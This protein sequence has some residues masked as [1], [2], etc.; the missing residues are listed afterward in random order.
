MSDN[1]GNLV[2]HWSPSAPFVRK[3]S[4]LAMELGLDERIERRRTPVAP[5]RP[6]PTLLAGDNPLSKLPAMILPDGN[7]LYDSRVIC[8][9]LDSIAERPRFFPRDGARRWEAL[10]RQA[11]G[12]GVSDIVIL[13]RDEAMRKENASQRHVET[14]AAKFE[15]SLD[16][17]Q[18]DIPDA[19]DRFDIGDV[20]I[21]CALSYLDFRAADIDWRQGRPRLAE[22][23]RG[24]EARDSVARTLLS[25]DKDI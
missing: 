4:I 20:A 25:S 23:Y 5:V 7:V 13:W 19:G 16:Q 11:L 24:F 21:G 14:M 1:S 22:W 9:Y 12:D 6:N 18:R 3:V 2:L 15:A 10:R 8:E 17:M